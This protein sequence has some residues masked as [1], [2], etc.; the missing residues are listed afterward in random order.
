MTFSIKFTAVEEYGVDFRVLRKQT[1]FA[2]KSKIRKH[3][4]KT[5]IAEIICTQLFSFS[6]FFDLIHVWQGFLEDS[7]MR[8]S[9]T[10]GEKSI[11]LIFHLQMDLTLTKMKPHHLL[12]PTY[13]L[14]SLHLLIDQS[15][16]YLGC[17]KKTEILC[18]ISLFIWTIKLF[19][20]KNSRNYI[21]RF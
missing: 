3:G 13:G 20:K 12:L 5:E 16:W 21:E 19:F 4:K 2:N 17:A 6:D 15:L 14:Q 8:V 18:W 9:E 11:S 1:K 10:S 7:R